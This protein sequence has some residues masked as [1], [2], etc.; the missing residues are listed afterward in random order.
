VVPPACVVVMTR[1]CVDGQV[2]VRGSASTSWVELLVQLPMKEN[3]RENI[4]DD[5]ESVKT[6]SGSKLDV[7]R[8]R[9]KP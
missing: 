8:G 7:W 1:P 2:V 3:R 9:L 5:F 6:S 4:V